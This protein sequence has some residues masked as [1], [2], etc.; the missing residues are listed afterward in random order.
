MPGTTLKDVAQMAGVSIRTVSNV[1]NGYP[2]VSPRLREKVLAAIDK[3]DYR[4]NLVARNLRTGRTGLIAL[5]VPEIDVPYFSELAR[6][7]IDEAEA[8]HYRV[9]IDQTDG[10]L[11]RE[12]DHIS[13]ATRA[14]LFDGV[15]FNP[16]EMSAGELAEVAK[17]TPLVLLGEHI[18]NGTVDH[19]AIDNIAAAR[20]ATEHLI[21]LGRRKIAAIGT[22]P[23]EQ[24]GTAQLRTRG[25]AATLTKHGLTIPP[26]LFKPTEKYHRDAGAKAMRSLL[27]EVPDVDAVFCFNDL[28]ASGA[29][30]E[31]LRSGRRVP[32]DIAVI[33]VDDIEEGRYSTPS[34]STISPDKATIAR[35]AVHR[36]IARM[37]EPERE[38]SE[39][40]A[41]YTLIA[42]QS[43]T[44][45]EG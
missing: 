26:S 17:R 32:D 18:A 4:P 22:H 13:G 27:S 29:I 11:A 23:D 30:K 1:V 36:L 14:Q 43:T 45:V 44:G 8:L 19:V 41:D 5:V 38:V 40:I 12:R 9:M 16:L 25:Y 15:I 21:G 24:I 6:A 37:R 28:L 31:I 2:S 33:G 3:L 10:D 39:F 34:L 42:R 35:E 20:D 7:I